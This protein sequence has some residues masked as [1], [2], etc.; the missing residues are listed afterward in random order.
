MFVT[1]NI[2]RSFGIWAEYRLIIMTG[3]TGALS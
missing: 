3:S 1:E 2:L